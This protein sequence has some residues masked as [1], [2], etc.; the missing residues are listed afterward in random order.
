MQRE[1]CVGAAKQQRLKYH[2]FD[3]TRD[4][5]THAVTDRGR[6]T[7]HGNTS[8]RRGDARDDTSGGVSVAAESLFNADQLVLRARGSIRRKLL[9]SG[10]QRSGVRSDAVISIWQ[11]K[12]AQIYAGLCAMIIVSLVVAAINFLPE[13]PQPI[14]PVDVLSRVRDCRNEV[15][16]GVNDRLT[17]G[18]WE[19]TST[20]CYMQVRGEAM[21]IDFNIRRSALVEQ[22]I[23]GRIILWMV[24]AITLS[25]VA[26][27]GLQL[28]AAYRLASAGHGDFTS[29][30]E[31]T[32]EQNKI[33]LKSSVTGLMILVVSFAFFM[34]YVLWVYTVK[35]LKQEFPETANV[36]NN[37]STPLMGGYGSPP[38]IPNKPK[39]EKPATPLPSTSAPSAN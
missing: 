22:Q 21:L 19:Q 26:L 11:S 24:V 39:A 14:A 31:V 18:M 38:A 13:R 12:V 8:R 9:V 36:T 28:V 7:R 29:P 23:E 17:L 27:A 32:L 10:T 2:A 35:E 16:G 1:Y 37:G 6:H 4:S 15:R 3:R 25:G 30:Q 34:V 5:T 33:S 20:I